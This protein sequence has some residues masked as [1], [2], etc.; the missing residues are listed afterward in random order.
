MDHTIFEWFV[1]LIILLLPIYTMI[2]VVKN[3]ERYETALKELI[4]ERSDLCLPTWLVVI[5]I[6][7]PLYLTMYSIRTYKEYFLLKRRKK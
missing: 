7:L 1:S 6:A 5:I 3:C 4:S 2:N